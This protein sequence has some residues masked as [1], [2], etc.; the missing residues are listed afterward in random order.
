[1]FEDWICWKTLKG[2]YCPLPPNTQLWTPT[3]KTIDRRDGLFSSEQSTVPLLQEV[4]SWSSVRDTIP[5][6]VFSGSHPPKSIGNSPP[7][8][9]RRIQL[10]IGRSCRRKHEDHV[11]FHRGEH[12]AHR[13]PG[14]FTTMK[15]DVPV[16][17]IQESCRTHS[18][19]PVSPYRSP[20]GR[21]AT[22]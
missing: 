12:G 9:I 5:G 4:M 11:W 1:M 20:V 17:A 21:I 13:R 6:I 14:I 2:N 22:V 7:R 8:R 15:P 10:F 18:H 16:T 19:S 3:R